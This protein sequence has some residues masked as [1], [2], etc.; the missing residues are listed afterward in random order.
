MADDLAADPIFG[1]AFSQLYL[2]QQKAEAAKLDNGQGGTRDPYQGE[3][4]MPNPQQYL[5]GYDNGLWNNVSRVTA[6][7]YGGRRGAAGEE[8]ARYKGLAAAADARQGA[9]IDNS[10]YNFDRQLEGTA[11]DQQQYGLDQYRNMIEGKG[12]SVAEH[13]MGL[14]LAQAQQNNANALQA[15]QQAAASRAASARGGGAN[16]A[17]AQMMAAQQQGGAAAAANQTNAQLGQQAAFQGG[18]L[19]AQEQQQALAGFSG[20][21]AQQ[22][23]QDLQRAG[24]S[25]DQAYKQATLEQ[26]QHALNDTRNLAYEGMRQKTFEDQLNAQMAGEAQNAGVTQSIQNRK[27]A[28]NEASANRATQIAGATVGAIGTAGASL[29]AQGAVAGQQAAAKSGSNGTLASNPYDTPSD[30]RGKTDIGSGDVAVRNQ[31]GVLGQTM[32]SAAQ[33]RGL[34]LAQRGLPAPQAPATTAPPPGA[35]SQPTTPQYTPPN[36]RVGSGQQLGGLPAPQQPAMAPMAP[37]LPAPQQPIAPNQQSAPQGLGRLAQQNIMSD[38]RAKENI[39]DGREAAR[40]QLTSATPPSIRTRDGQGIDLGGDVE[41][42]LAAERLHQQQAASLTKRAYGRQAI[43]G[44]PTFVS[45]SRMLAGNE[46]PTTGAGWTPGEAA[47]HAWLEAHPEEAA[48]YGTHPEVPISEGPSGRARARGDDPQASAKSPRAVSDQ[49]SVMKPNTYRYKEP[50]KHGEGERI[51]VMAQDMEKGPY[52]HQLVKDTPEGKKIDGAGGLSLAL[53]GTADHEKR[54]RAIEAAGG[55][56]GFAVKRLADTPPAQGMMG[57]P[58]DAATPITSAAGGGTINAML[59]ARRRAEEEDARR[60]AA[61]LASQGGGWVYP[62]GGL[63]RAAG[64]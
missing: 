64:Q 50:Q 52:G 55:A 47:R 38:T 18:M 28:E 19:R 42:Q 11:R 3:G 16:L 62:G 2:K 6:F 22:R 1:P 57:Q 58:G 23:A 48:Y 59:D 39:G 46:R 12:P 49:L 34:G 15:A 17:A 29:A 31:F 61:A 20:M 53:A 13:Q 14:G 54:L 7:D 4:A 32:P 26:Q 43:P 41:D 63:A 27:S 10:N 60:R 30:I 25:A 56:P 45:P 35:M 40:A 5:P 51:G 37:R 36:M 21:S 24:M 33:G 9:Q 44:A 8:E